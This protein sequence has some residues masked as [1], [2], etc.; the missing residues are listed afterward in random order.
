[1]QWIHHFHTCQLWKNHPSLDQLIFLF[2]KAGCIMPLE[3]STF[4]ILAIHSFILF[5]TTGIAEI[6]LEIFSL[7][8]RIFSSVLCSLSNSIASESIQTKNLGQ[9][10]D[11]ISQQM[12]WHSRKIYQTPILQ[13]LKSLRTCIMF[14]GWS[15]LGPV[16][17]AG[18][19]GSLRRENWIESGFELIWNSGSVF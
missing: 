18:Q 14:S 15:S 8:N 13:T 11:Y 12:K 19:I 16:I 2:L 5:K 4:S 9:Y 7:S 1:M 17:D 10:L 6:L 3:E